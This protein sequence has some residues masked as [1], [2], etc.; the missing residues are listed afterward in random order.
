MSR[1]L[2][3]LALSGTILL[4]ATVLTACAGNAG[5]AGTETAEAVDPVGTW[6]DVATTDEPSLAFGN[7]GSLSGTDGC[8]RLVGSWTAEGDTVTFVEVAS[9][10]M[11]CEGVDTWLAAL[12]TATI[13]GDTLT[14][15]DESGEEIGTLDRSS[16]DA[17]AI[18]GDAES[19]AFIGTWGTE[20][21]GTASGEPFIVIAAD[22]SA[23]GS[24]G[25]N[26][27][28]GSTWTVD[29]DTIEF[30]P[31]VATLMACEG[32]DQWLN[33]KSTATVDGDTMTFYDES[34]AEIGTLP[35]TA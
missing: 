24:D 21:T 5:T 34:G 7:G 2:Q 29:G 25:C 32:V 19:A 10:R 11:L 16:D 15:F 30:T 31:G 12:A 26:T 35:R 17:G 20:S 33:A 23:S 14:V 9:T 18:S 4:A 28:G 22:G 6:G 8:N 13:S 3:R 27:F 1:T